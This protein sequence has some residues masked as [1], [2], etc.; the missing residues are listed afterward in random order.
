MPRSLHMR[1]YIVLV[2]SLKHIV[3]LL[4]SQQSYHLTNTWLIVK[5]QK[6]PSN[7]L[8]NKLFCPKCY[9]PGPLCRALHFST[10][11]TLVLCITTL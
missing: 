5:I 7:K 1:I 10:N 6:K 9:N 4:M 3:C 2:E 8:V 11:S